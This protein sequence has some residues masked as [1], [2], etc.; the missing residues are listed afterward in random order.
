MNKVYDCCFIY[1]E[2]PLLE[3]RLRLL[4]DVVDKFIVVEGK[5]SF[6]GNPH[7]LIGQEIIDRLGMQ[8]QVIYLPIDFPKDMTDSW[9]RE[10]YARDSA[11]LGLVQLDLDNSDTI[12]IGDA[13]EIVDPKYISMIKVYVSTFEL[14]ALKLQFLSVKGNLKAKVDGGDYNFWP[15]RACNISV[16]KYFQSSLTAVRIF[17]H[18][19]NTLPFYPPLDLEGKYCGW[20]FSSM[21]GPKFIQD[22][23]LNYAHTEFQDDKYVNLGTLERIYAEGRDF[24]QRDGIELVPYNVDLLPELVWSI[25]GCAEYLG[26][27]KERE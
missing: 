15:T 21:G 10:N 13:D 2:A 22:K 25:P 12:I 1:N 23:L 18:C 20:H 26:L 17:E 8:D 3:L 19:S 9:K 14:I 6:T 24:L 7:K 11:G 27:E 4:K 5:E 16:L